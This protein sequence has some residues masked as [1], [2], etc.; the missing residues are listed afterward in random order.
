M[1]L[2][3]LY[4]E[5]TKYDKENIIIYNQPKRCSHSWTTNYYRYIFGFIAAFPPTTTASALSLIDTSNTTR[6]SNVYPVYNVQST[7]CSA[8]PVNVDDYGIQ[9][10]TGNTAEAL[11]DYKLDTKILQGTTSGKLA[12]SV[13]TNSISGN[14]DF[15]AT[16]YFANTSGDTIVVAEVGY[17]SALEI[18]PTTYNV[19]LARDVL[20]SPVTILNNETLKVNYTI[21]VVFP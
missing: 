16:R 18:F 10:G 17:V 7:W 13:G 15:K 14:M 20:S 19:L 21:S 6:S 2:P 3:L 8:A 12:Y 9:V 11:T 4:I 1:K 5:L